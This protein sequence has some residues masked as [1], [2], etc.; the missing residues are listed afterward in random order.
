MAERD[1]RAVFIAAWGER[2]VSEIT[3]LD[4][5]EIINTK[6]R[7]APQMARALLV[8]IKRFFGWCV[9]QEIYGLSASPC[10]GLSGKKLIGEL[11]S[12]DRRLT[13]AEI[14]AFWRATGRM[15]YPAG[16]VY[17]MLAAHRAAAER[18]R[19][20]FVAGSSGQHHHHPG[21]ED[22]GPG[23][24]GARTSGAD[25]RRRCG[26]SSHRCRASRTGRSCSP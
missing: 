9:D 2:P 13:D 14:F 10:E 11:Q 15:G 3:K 18:G 24:Q 16:S 17:R 25:R 5:L 1:L 22:E 4:V 8:L 19:A 23:G 26:R 12:R 21:V 7:T 6:K 20:D